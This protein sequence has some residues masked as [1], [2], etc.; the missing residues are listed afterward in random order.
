MKVGITKPDE[1]VLKEP[2][3]KKANHRIPAANL[4]RFSAK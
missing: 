2:L 4:K 3:H 1:K